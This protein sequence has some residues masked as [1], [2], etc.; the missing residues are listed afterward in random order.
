ME[1]LTRLRKYTPTE[2]YMPTPQLLIALLLVCGCASHADHVFSARGLLVGSSG[3]LPGYG[4]KLVRAKE[5]PTTVLGDDGSICR[6]TAERFDQ[7]D[8]GDWLSCEWTIEPEPTA[9][10][11]QAG[12]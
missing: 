9:S 8:V 12:A 2:G 5:A 1:T 6:L 7:V 4:I 3:A 11:A 10:I